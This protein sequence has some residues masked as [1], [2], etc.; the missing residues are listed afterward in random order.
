MLP[1]LINRGAVGRKSHVEFTYALRFI[2]PP[3][4]LASACDITACV[5]ALNSG[6]TFGDRG[7]G[8]FSLPR[9]NMQRRRSPSLLLQGDRKICRCRWYSTAVCLQGCRMYPDDMQV[10]PARLPPYSQAIPHC[11]WASSL[12]SLVAATPTS[13]FSYI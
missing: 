1:R 13:L 2:V 3:R 8:R 5:W 10:R 11:V 7:A 9:R 6:V 12:S 4:P